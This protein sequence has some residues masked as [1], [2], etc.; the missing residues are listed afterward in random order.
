[1]PV[2]A[3]PLLRRTPAGSSW[4]RFAALWASSHLAPTPSCGDGCGVTSRRSR[5]AGGAG[6]SG[7]RFS[8]ACAGRL[9]WVLACAAMWPANA[10]GPG[11]CQRNMNVAHAQA[12]AAPAPRPPSQLF[13]PRQSSPNLW[14]GH[15]PPPRPNRTPTPSLPRF[16]SLGGRPRDPGGG[17]GQPDG[18]RAATGVQARRLPAL[19]VS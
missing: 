5:Q 14:P 7:Q 11:R 6:S 17:A 19:Q 2:C 18:G 1:M 13:P 8:Q 10:R 4:C 9:V 3:C 15:R 12:G 16:L